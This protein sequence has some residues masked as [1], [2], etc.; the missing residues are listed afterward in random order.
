[1]DNQIKDPDD[2]V[3]VIRYHSQK[4]EGD[5]VLW[6]HS[7]LHKRISDLKTSPCADHPMLKSHGLW[8]HALQSVGIVNQQGDVLRKFLETEAKGK[9]NATECDAGD[10]IFLDVFLNPEVSL[11]TTYER[12]TPP[13]FDEE[14]LDEEL[15]D[16][17][18]F[19]KNEDSLHSDEEP[20][21]E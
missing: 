17:K 4:I 18:P 7:Q 2:R 6:L 11:E 12:S 16:E 10:Q 19:D 15:L 9:G 1:M 20:V 8:K 14:L 3:N 21:D 5:M 13:P